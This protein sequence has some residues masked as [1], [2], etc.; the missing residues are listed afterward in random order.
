VGILGEKSGQEQGVNA[1]LC[2]AARR[3]VAM[4]G[5]E[6]SFFVCPCNVL[7]V[8]VDIEEMIK[9]VW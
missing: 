8:V 4:G 7:G 5:R 6:V 3:N 1:A 2:E 9:D